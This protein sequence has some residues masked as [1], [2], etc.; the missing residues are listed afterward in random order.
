[1]GLAGRLAL[2]L[3]VLVT[4]T[5]LLIGG[6]S[7]VTTDQQVSGEIDQFLRERANEIADG[8]RDG[9]RS[10]GGRNNGARRDDRLGSIEADAEVQVLAAD[11]SVATRTGL[12]LPVT[13]ADLAIAAE[14]GA[15]LLRTV[16]I[17]GT[18][19]R[20]ITQPQP[21][22]GA[23]QVA[24]SLE[25]TLTVLG[26]VRSQML[27]VIG[28]LVAVA[29]GLGWALA[30]R[31]TRPLRELTA[32]V[33]SVAK[34]H[35]TSVPLS[36]S[37]DD[38]VGRLARAF[39]HMLQALDRSRQQ[40]RRLVQ[41]AAHE[42]RTPLTSITANIDWLS[43]ADDVDEE[44]R[45]QALAGVRRELRELNGV[46]T[47]IVDLAT[48]DDDM[49]PMS[50]LDLR[51]VAGD[52]VT[53]WRGRVDRPIVLQAE[54]TPVRGD[55]DALAR[56]ITNLVANADKYSPP[57]TAITIDLA[58]GWLSVSDEGPG[59]PPEDRERIFDRFFRRPADRATTGS[60]LGLS[61][62]ASIVAAH[63]GTPTADESIAGGARIGFRLPVIPHRGCGGPWP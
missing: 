40:Q 55:A 26:M 47:E 6:A 46:I 34:T 12:P 27:P 37:G 22:G 11:G 60:G 38:E 21:G 10:D 7:L 44:T 15:A 45:R 31:T 32:A 28:L 19:Y 52:V 56:A 58:D 2:T 36:I 53:R 13:E 23:V 57:G 30:Q 8:N 49:T 29:G 35:D 42:L 51:Q 50:D 54:A 63:S 14:D 48:D 9:P 24:R 16:Q 4:I 25:A 39:T 61:I 5:S 17:D 59:I 18:Q 41:D 3:A 62:V 33:D 43:H 20:L 1:M